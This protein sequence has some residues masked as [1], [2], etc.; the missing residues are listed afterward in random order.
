MHQ[1]EPWGG[2]RTALEFPPAIRRYLIFSKTHAQGPPTTTYVCMYVAPEVSVRSECPPSEPKVV[3]LVEK[4]KK[5]RL[6]L[7]SKK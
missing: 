1:I 6:G 2:W 5:K 3:Y 4:K 7:G